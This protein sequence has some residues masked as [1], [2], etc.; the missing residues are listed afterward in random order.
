M[1]FVLVL[2]VDIFGKK[3]LVKIIVVIGMKNMLF[4]CCNNWY[5]FFGVFLMNG[6]IV[7]VKIVSIVDIFLFIVISCNLFVCGFM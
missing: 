1:S 6:V 4:N 2:I 3:K 5:K 7:M